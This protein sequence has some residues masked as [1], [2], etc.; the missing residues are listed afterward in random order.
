MK[1]DPYTS[2]HPLASPAMGHWGTCPLP[3]PTQFTSLTENRIVYAVATVPKV[4]IL[5][6]PNELTD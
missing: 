6:N 4:L 1:T 2:C 5:N 3:P